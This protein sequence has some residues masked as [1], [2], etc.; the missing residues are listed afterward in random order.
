MIPKLITYDIDGTLV[1]EYARTVPQVNLDAIA[2]AK[3]AG[4]VICPSSGRTHSNLVRL[5]GKYVEDTYMITMNGGAIYGPGDTPERFRYI[6]PDMAEDIFRHQVEVGE[7][8]PIIFCENSMY[9]YNGDEEM[10]RRLSEL[11]RGPV[12]IISAIREVEEPMIKIS[13]FCRDANAL[14]ERLAEGFMDKVNVAVAGKEWVDYTVSDKG[15]GIS[16]MCEILGI[17]LA[18]TAAIGDNYNDVP[19][20]EKAAYPIIMS[21]ASAELRK[22]YPMQSDSFTE[23]IDRLMSL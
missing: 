6:E 15:T 2:R 1:P 13:S 21:G 3:A 10:A 12:T 9:L 19:M 22:R 4:C 14:F 8:C 20:L 23:A 17:S 18:E 11:H 7:N 5:L 16:D